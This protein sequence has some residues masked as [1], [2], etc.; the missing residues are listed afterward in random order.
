VLATLALHANRTL[1]VRE[2]TRGAWTEPPRAVKSNIRTYIAR[3]RAAFEAAGEDGSRLVTEP[4]GYR[5]RV[6]H[7]ELDVSVFEELVAQGMRAVEQADPGTASGLFTRA[8]AMWRGDP[9]SGVS[10]GPLLQAETARLDERRLAVVEQWARAATSVGLHSDVVAEL[11]RL[12]RVKPQRE[13]LWAHLMLAL[14]RGGDRAG[15]LEAYREAYRR[16]TGELGVAPSQRLQ[17]LHRQILAGEAG[18]AWEPPARV[19]APLPR[20]IPVAPE[21]FVGRTEEM[22]WLDGSLQGVRLIVGT[23]GVGKTALALQWAHRTAGRF[24]DGQLHVDLRGHAAAPPVHPC[25]AL[26][27][28]LRALGVEHDRVPGNVAE[29]AAL[30]RSLLADRK[31]LVLLDNAASAEHVRPLLPGGSGCL[32]VVTSRDRLTGL[33]AQE[34]ARVLRLD[35]LARSDSVELIGEITG[36]GL[37]SAEPEAVQRLA[38]L[39]VDL[40]LALRI[41][42][43]RLA[44]APPAGI[45]EFALRLEAGDRLAALRIDDDAANAV[46]ASFELSATRLA[47][48][49]RR[50]FRLIGRHDLPELETETAARL[51][52]AT[53]EQAAD[54]LAALSAAHLLEPVGTGRYRMHKLL[55]LFAAG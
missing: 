18:A 27:M 55:R 43:T 12:V 41:A 28:F 34:G 8:L 38:E 50:L 54:G 4:A 15:A 45:A 29:A 30:Y 23:A 17:Q 3:L 37:L 26:G 7:R 9:L 49:P 48:L 6:Q 2:L 13:R 25:E 5:L 21:P 20:Q 11:S 47:E 16:F 10:A 42:A 39:C 32:A 51:L 40:P 35:V 46:A 24:P 36:R 31:V 33:V 19:A 52:E 14:W 53:A 44:A 1:T 22:G